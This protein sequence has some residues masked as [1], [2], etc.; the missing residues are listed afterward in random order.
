MSKEFTE[1]SESFRL[2]RGGGGFVVV[3][4]DVGGGGAG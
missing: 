1:V 2:A 3:S 4:E